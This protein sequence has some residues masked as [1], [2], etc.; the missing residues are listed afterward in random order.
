[1]S[2]FDFKAAV[3]TIKDKI[4][5]YIT[6]SGFK[7]V[8]FKDLEDEEGNVPAG[9]ADRGFTIFIDGTEKDEDMNDS[10]HFNMNTE[11]TF[12]L[13]A[14][15]DYYLEN[16]GYA[17]EAVK[18]LWDIDSSANIQAKNIIPTFSNEPV[19]DNVKITFNEINFLIKL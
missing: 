15:N 7:Y 18:L 16:L 6:G 8:S 14:I 4:E 10:V 9:L 11:I 5:S 17:V 19:G 1:M 13:S 12:Y 2:A 3:K